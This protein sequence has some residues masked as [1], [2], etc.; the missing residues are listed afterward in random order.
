MTDFDSHLDSWHAYTATPWGRIRYAVVAHTLAR[1][2][3]RLGERLRVL[4]VGGGDGLDSLPLARVGHEVTVLDPSEPLLAD[5]AEAAGREGLS[6][7]TLV[8]G[9]EDLDGLPPYDV[10][11]C[12]FVLQYRPD[13]RKDLAA[14]VRAVRPGGLLSVIAPNPASRVLTS[15][16]RTGPAAALSALRAETETSNTFNTEVRKIEAD[17]VAR[18]LEDDLGAQVVTRYGGRIAT[19]LVTDEAAKHREDY[20][21]DLE[22]LEIALC[23]REPFL[24]LGMFWQLIARR[25]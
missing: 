7:T 12:H 22:R 10:V 8:G 2:T 13:E 17:R 3:A 20:Y 1:E 18:I 23:D 21:A 25:G 4:D 9:I 19:D 16:L 5:A 24:R 6:V 11:L 14:L 15:L